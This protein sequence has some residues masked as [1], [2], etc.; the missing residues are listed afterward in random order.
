MRTK[1]TTSV[2]LLEDVYKTGVAGEVVSVAPGFARNYLVPKKMALPATSGAMRQFEN[3]RSRAV[4]RR[5][6]RQKEY[7]EVAARIEELKLYYPVRASEAGKLYGSISPAMITDSIN[8]ALGLEIDRRRVGD[9]PL[10][11]LG[12][13]AVPV[14]LDAGLVANV[15]V[16]VFREGEDPREV[17]VEEAV[18][19]QV[20]DDVVP[21]A[22]SDSE[23]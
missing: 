2:I 1:K 5:A 12:E 11:E 4:V 22:D 7:G 8:E 13:F 15:A 10:K 19:N 20:A 14:R 21:E 9:H 6:E 18:V 16:T 23:A 17:A 3:L